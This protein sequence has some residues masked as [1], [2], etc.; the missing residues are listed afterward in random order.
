MQERAI[1][2]QMVQDLANPQVTAA[3]FYMIAV[4]PQA[5]T[6]GHLKY[7][8]IYGEIKKSLLK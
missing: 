4:Q 6:A 7:N 3:K 5:P 2:Q 8:Q 1:L